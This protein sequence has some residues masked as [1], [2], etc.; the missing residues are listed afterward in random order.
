MNLFLFLRNW[1]SSLVEYLFHSA[2]EQRGGGESWL[3]KNHI[4]KEQWANWC[5]ALAGLLESFAIAIGGA[6]RVTL[7]RGSVLLLDYPGISAKDVQAA[8]ERRNDDKK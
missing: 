6:Q 1:R 8:I 3:K 4:H 7:K 2:D 5:F